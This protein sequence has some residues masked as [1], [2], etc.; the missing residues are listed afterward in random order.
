MSDRPTAAELADAV[1]GFLE[2]EVQPALQ[3]DRQRFRALVAANALSILQR[4]LT[5]G[6]GLQ[7]EEEELLG[8]LLGRPL[9]E[10]ARAL[11]AELCRRLRKGEVPAGTRAALL[12]IAAMKLSIASPKYLKGGAPK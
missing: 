5:L 2:D 6:P 8:A 3:S 12:R 4:D 10:G 11:N 7:R 9:A 1:R